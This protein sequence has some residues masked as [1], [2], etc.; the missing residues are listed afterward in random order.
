MWHD[1]AMAS[2]SDNVLPPVDREAAD[3]MW[4]EYSATR[5]DAV[6]ACPEYTV[7]YF[8]DSPRLANE[9]LRLVTHGGK[10]GTSELVDAYRAG[11]EDLPRIGSHWIA[12][13][14][15]GAPIIV[16]RS[17]D[18]RVAR[19]DEVDADF[20]AAEGEDDRSLESWRREHSAYWTRTC[21]ARGTSWS[22]Q[23][24][25]VCERFSV[26]WPPDLAD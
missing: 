15:S 26:V 9:L 4:A 10:R 19:F 21:A 12:C 8:G 23:D 16:M 5:P 25:I 20:A 24:E 2:T 11:G 17:T 1:L 13:D 18:L 6:G 22:E 14:G 3:A 7:E